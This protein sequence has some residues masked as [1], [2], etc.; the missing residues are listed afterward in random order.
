MPQPVIDTMS[1]RRFE[2]YLQAAGHDRDRAVALYVWNAKIGASFHIPIQ[3][4][5]VALRNRVN[6]ALVRV[7]P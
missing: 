3:A 1:Q 4:A 6:H 2:T 5:E 7:K